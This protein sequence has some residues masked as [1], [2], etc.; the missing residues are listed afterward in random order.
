MNLRRT[1]IIGGILTS[2]LLSCNHSK[3][4]VPEGLLKPDKLIPLLVE[5][6]LA[7]GYLHHLKFT[8]YRKKDTAFFIY[9]AILEKYDISRPMFDSTI[10]FY[11]QYPDEFAK[12]YDEVLEKL[13]IMEGQ[14]MEA[15]SLANTGDEKEK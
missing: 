15:D 12:I 4:V 7:D 8:E 3:M 13:A 5:L 14:V 11:G 9:P 2:I 10:L 6:H 1:I